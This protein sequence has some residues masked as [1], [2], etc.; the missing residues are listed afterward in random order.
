MKLVVITSEVTINNIKY[1]KGSEIKVSDSV[2]IDLTEVKKCAK[3]FTPKK[4]KSK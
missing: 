3:I 1:K 2:F 4:K